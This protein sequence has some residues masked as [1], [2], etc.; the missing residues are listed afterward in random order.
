ML[1]KPGI[2]DEHL[3]ARVQAEYGLSA[4]GLTFLPLGADVNTAVYQLETGDGKAY[5]LKLRSGLFDE[6]TVAVPQFL[7]S[8]SIQAIIAPLPTRN[9]R[10]WG[11]LDSYRMILYPYIPG[12]D[13]YEAALSDQQWINLGLALKGVHTALVPP[14]IQK[15]LQRESFSSQWR[16]MVRQFQAQVETTIYDDPVADRLA[17]FMRT[18][19]SQISYMVY[20]SGELSHLLHSASLEFV[21]CHTDVHP[22]N[23]LLSTDGALYLVDWDNPLLAPKERDL[24]SIGA[25]MAGDLPGGREES[26]FYQGYGDVEID[27]RALAYYRYE[28]IIVD[29]AE[30]CKQLLRSNE[31]GKDRQQ[32]YHYFT[33]SFLPGHVV[34]IAFQSDRNFSHSFS[35]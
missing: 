16:E 15:H 32:S 1:E 34:E 18:R 25:G 3:I 14:D 17:A 28:R 22:G 21:L 20:R 8:Q 26:L 24:M 5:F 13:G 31:G 30:F 10:N 23:Y 2:E 9:H 12:R 6:M 4:S 29:I 11:S 35:L 33:S 7:H 27:W 19:R